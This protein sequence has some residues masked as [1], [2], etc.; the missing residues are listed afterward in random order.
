MKD[1]G[2]L[3]MGS[4]KGVLYCEA[5]MDNDFTVDDVMSMVDEIN[6]NYDGCTDIILKKA[7]SYSVAVEAQLLLREK[8]KE[9]RNFV[10]VA[11]TERKKVASEYAANSY[12]SKYNTKVAS[13]KE[14]AFEILKANKE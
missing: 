13:S 6:Q 10:Y 5:Y 8:V 1:D 12:M 3:L 11:D 4:Y 7:G 14:E 9:F 2:R